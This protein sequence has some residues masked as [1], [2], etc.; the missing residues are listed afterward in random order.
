[1]SSLKSS[2]PNVGKRRRISI[3][4]EDYY[5]VCS[6]GTDGPAVDITA[7]CDV[8]PYSKTKRI[9]E[10][11]CAHINDLFEEERP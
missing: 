2:S 4:G 10:T 5:L 7:D 8:P 9:V 1:M 11:L 6:N 3:E